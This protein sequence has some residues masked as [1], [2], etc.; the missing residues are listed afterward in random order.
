MIVF[1]A[2][3][4]RQFYSS[5]VHHGFFVLSDIAE[6]CYKCDDAR[7]PNDEGG[8]MWNDP[9]IGIEWPALD[10]DAEFDT[11]KIILSDK[12]RLHPSLVEVLSIQ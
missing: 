2:E 7:Y 11:T 3:N 10:G 1:S 12:D 8:F 6:F 4:K 5:Q 9:I